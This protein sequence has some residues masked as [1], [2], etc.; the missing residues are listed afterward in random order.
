VIR[1][2]RRPRAE[3]LLFGRLVFFEVVTDTLEGLHEPDPARRDESH[4][5]E[6]AWIGRQFNG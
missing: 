1:G 6:R 4:S 3:R 5:R 2:A